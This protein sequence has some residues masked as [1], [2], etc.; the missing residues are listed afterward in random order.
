MTIH[1]INILINITLTLYRIETARNK[2]GRFRPGS[3]VRGDCK[4]IMPL[5]MKRELVVI[6]NIL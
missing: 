1:K 4:Y 5:L 2:R 6:D 3:Q